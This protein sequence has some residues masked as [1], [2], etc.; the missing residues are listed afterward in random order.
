MANRPKSDPIPQ[1]SLFEMN[2]LEKAA[3]LLGMPETGRPFHDPG[4]F[5]GTS[6]FTANGWP[7]TFYPAGMKPTDY[8]SFYATRFK[9]VEIDSTYYG[10]ASA[11]TVTSWRDKTPFQCE[12]AADGY[13]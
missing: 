4:L 13:T 3:D 1:P 7:G 8:L 12:D 11:L 10:P 6:A 9:T 5:V 2:K